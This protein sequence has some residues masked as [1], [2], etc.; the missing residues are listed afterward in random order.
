MPS[1]LEATLDRVARLSRTGSAGDVRALVR[2][3]GSEDWQARR[4]AAEA[5]SSTVWMR[6]D[7]IDTEAL[8]QEL[9]VA[10]SDN[11]DAGKRGA[12]I[13]A[14]EGIGAPALA[15]LAAGLRSANAPAR[16]ALAGVIG[17]AG[18]VE[19]VRLLAP[20]VEDEDTNVAAAS[21]SALGRTR[22]PEATATLL[23]KLDSSDEWLRFAAVGA[24]GE[25]GDERAVPALERLLEE[26]LMQE[27]AAS[28]LAEIAT[29]SAANALARHLRAA[30]GTLRTE[31][32]GAL[33][34][35]SHDER[36]SPRALRVA[37]R[38]STKQ[39]F[40]ESADAA[41]LA[42]V[43]R[44]TNTADPA[45]ARI[46]LTALGWLG[47]ER[48]VAII[49]S[50]LA[51]PALSKVARRALSDLSTET[52]A[53]GAMLETR[54]SLIPP[55]ELATA[56][57]ETQSLAALEAAA[58]L[59]VEAT[60]A[61]MLEASLSA[62]AQS[63]DWLRGLIAASQLDA[64]RAMQLGENLRNTLF[65]AHAR[66]LV[67]IAETLGVLAPQLS[68]ASRRAI[69]D[70]LTQADDED[71]VL[72][73]LAY[74]RHADSRSAMKEAKRAQR[75]RSAL[76]RMAAIEILSRGASGEDVSLALHLTDEV[77][78]VRRSAMRAMRYAARP[79]IY[80]ALVAGLADEDI[81]VTAEAVLTLGM[82]YGHDHE[83]HARLSEALAAP[84]PVCRV[85]AA[86]ALATCADQ[87]DWRALS[88]MAR[89]DTQAEARRA[90]VLAFTH[91]TL[92]RTVLSV[93][94]AALKDEA[95]SVRR[96]AVE[97]LAAS[98]E[99]AAQRLLR[100]TAAN[101]KEDSAVRGAALRALAH[102]RSP[103]TI[104]LVCSSAISGGDP[105]LVEDAYAALVWLKRTHRAQLRKV[106]RTC[107]PRSASV[108][109][110]I[111]ETA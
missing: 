79:E 25:L 110:F 92:P 80:R 68:N 52:T 93:A 70:V 63:R 83:A 87:R 101:E 15:F 2:L 53:L 82:L 90:A 59:S 49:A 84:H 50:A 9:I 39:A 62:L 55:A 1:T 45:R 18:G 58:R 19:A 40:R 108:I 65:E 60:D 16:I 35:L 78:G 29:L 71:Q 56:I 17:N 33:V 75:H 3:L 5:I 22:E 96:A 27:A 67:E 23:Q 28:A 102:H 76:V 34:L 48:A 105:T 64:A 51:D 31:I 6:P 107:A 74:L 103:E 86:Q 12:A 44:L 98:G 8:F 43:M 26:A 38:A 57:G 46:G 91:C 10:V 30:D 37:L 88:S 21:V 99:A 32:L 89:R 41:T 95:W 24:L 20:L 36:P 109:N 54:S 4:A 111:L 69:L 77:A 73:R 100:Q 13:A 81:W 47:D 94:R 85:A 11:T 72:A 66:A 61:E 104:E 7:E 106:S 42:D 14:L 97:A